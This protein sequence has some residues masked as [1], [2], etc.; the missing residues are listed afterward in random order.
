MK[1]LSIFIIGCL[2]ALQGFSQENVFLKREF[3]DTKPT[4]ETIDLKI[5]EGNDIA[6]ANESNSKKIAEM[7]KQKNE[8]E[9]KIEEMS[10]ECMDLEDMIERLKNELEQ[11][12]V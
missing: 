9:Q 1:K 2:F 7:K 4:V 10:G 6:Q 5:R 11:S 8:S 3:W 12:Q